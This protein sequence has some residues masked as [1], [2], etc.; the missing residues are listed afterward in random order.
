MSELNW[1]TRW[2]HSLTAALKIPVMWQCISITIPRGKQVH[3]YELYACRP[4][5]FLWNT[6]PG[7]T[8]EYQI[9]FS[10]VNMGLGSPCRSQ[11]QRF[12][13]LLWAL[14]ELKVP[15]NQNACWFILICINVYFTFLMTLVYKFA[16]YI[17]Y[18]FFQYIFSKYTKTRILK[19]KP[20]KL[21]F[22]R[23]HHQSIIIELTYCEQRYWYVVTY[24][25]DTWSQ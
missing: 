8:R 2:L 17:L 3:S 4:I 7:E 20:S 24:K 19:K 12:R 6:G 25:L 14:T 16:S 21:R 15:W 13:I 1:P 11:W 23:W 5:L 18:Y 9:A 22:L 10:L